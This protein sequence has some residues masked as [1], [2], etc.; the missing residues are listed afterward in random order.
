VTLQDDSLYNSLY[1]IERLNIF[2]KTAPWRFFWLTEFWNVSTY[3]Q[4][5]IRVGEKVAEAKE[6]AATAALPG[7]VSC[8]K[9]METKVNLL[10]VD[11]LIRRKENAN[12]QKLRK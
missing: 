4:V 3:F 7:S 6:A 1:N 8:S 11:E 5:F 2:N 9:A 10:S 12:K